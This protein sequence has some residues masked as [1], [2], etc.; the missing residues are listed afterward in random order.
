MVSPL[1]IESRLVNIE[2]GSSQRR[3]FRAFTFSALSKIFCLLHDRQCLLFF[4]HCNTFVFYLIIV[5]RLFNFGT[6][7]GEKA[8][9]F[10]CVCVYIYVC[11]VCI[12]IPNWCVFSK[13]AWNGN[14]IEPKI[15]Q[16]YQALSESSYWSIYSG[17]A[18]WNAVLQCRKLNELCIA[19]QLMYFIEHRRTQFTK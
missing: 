8:C 18:H 4:S 1:I 7:L 10:V 15:L 5:H 9:V 13:C 11:C 19:M 6:H 12:N 14:L 16:L 3:V 2:S 17:W